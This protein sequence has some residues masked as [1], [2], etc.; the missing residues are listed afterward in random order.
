M[1]P[2]SVVSY[3]IHT[4]ARTG[5]RLPQINICMYTLY[6]DMMLLA[7]SQATYVHIRKPQPWPSSWGFQLEGFSQA[8]TRFVG[9]IGAQHI[10]T[11]RKVLSK[12]IWHV[13]YALLWG[14]GS[15]ASELDS[16]RMPFLSETSFFGG[17]YSCEK[18]V[19][20]GSLPSW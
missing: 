3:A 9:L 2:N 13:P 18:Y 12:S 6:P 11:R 16:L 17:R 1:V 15:V 5:Y 8:Y 10:C 4:I 7:A 20:L 14:L 19:S